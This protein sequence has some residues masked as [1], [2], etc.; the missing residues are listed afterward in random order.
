MFGRILPL[1][2]PLLNNTDRVNP[3]WT[4]SLPRLQKPKKKRTY[5]SP[6][7]SR[8][9]T[10][11]PSSSGRTKDQQKRRTKKSISTK[12]KRKNRRR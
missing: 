11:L 10:V 7:G 1:L 5:L 3:D 4:D 12:S 8:S 9:H 6:F 2:I